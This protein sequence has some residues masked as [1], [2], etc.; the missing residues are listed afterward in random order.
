MK[1]VVGRI[2]EH[3]FASWFIVSATL[4]GIADIIRAARGEKRE[5]IIVT[6][7]SEPVPNTE[8]S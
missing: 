6:R 4:G 2:L 8:E 5:P 1:D 7:P 3:P